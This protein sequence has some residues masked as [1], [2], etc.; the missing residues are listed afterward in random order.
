MGDFEYTLGLFAN[1]YPA[2]ENS[3]FGNFIKR[4]VDSL[5]KRGVIVKKAVKTSKSVSAYPKFF[6]D[7]FKLAKSKECDIFQAEYIPHSSFVPAFFKGD[8]PLVIKFLGTDGRIYPYKNKINKKLIESMIKRAD[9]VIAVSEELKSH[10]VKFGANPENTSVFATGVDTNTFVNLDKE[11]CRLKL[12]LPLDK[13]IFI[14]IGR[15]CTPKGINELIE[16]AKQRP[17]MLFIFCGPGIIPK[18]TDNCIFTGEISHQE[19]HEWLC[20]SDCLIL[21][22]YSEGLPNVLMESLSSE[23]PAI[24]TD[25]G[26]CRE[27]VEDYKSG[28]LIP[29]KDIHALLTSVDWINDNQSNIKNMGIYGREVMMNKYDRE[30]IIDKLIKLHKKLIDNC[31]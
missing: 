14:F 21:P 12:N 28:L 4:D 18:H 15:L 16:T 31:P 8:T 22:S 3:S 6:M 7:S 26:G 5:E 29:P 30:I 19:V 2:D 11:A 20:A 10:L 9:H 13:P 1:M 23:R 17:N 27:V 24:T 25:V